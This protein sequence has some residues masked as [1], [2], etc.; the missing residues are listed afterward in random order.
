MQV[1]LAVVRLVLEIPVAVLT[2][3]LAARLLGVRRSWLATAS[4][5]TVAWILAN[6]LW[7]AVNHWE[8]KAAGVHLATI[9]LSLVFAMLAAVTFDFAARPGSLAREDR[10][11][12]IVFP[13]PVRELRRH[14]VP[15]I[16]YREIIR[17]A[18]R[19]GLVHGV[20][21]RRRR[22]SSSPP[23]DLNVAVRTTLEASGVVMTKLGQMAS[24]RDDLLPKALTVEL[25]RLQQHVEPVA[26]EEMQAE[27]EAELGRAVN[28]V[29]ADFSWE[30]I[31]SA[32]IAQ[33]YRA[34]LHGGD[35]VVVKVQRPGI[36]RVVE[37]DTA[38]LAH[39]AHTFERRTLE[40]RR[41]RASELAEEFAGG[42][43]E[44]LDFALEADNAVD[45]ATIDSRVR[46]PR[47][48]RELS[49]RRILV[50]EELNGITVADVGSR[51]IVDRA[52]LADQLVHAMFAQVMHGHFHAD[53]H[54][55]N[56]LLLDDGALGLIDFGSTGRLDPA[57]RSALMDIMF[58][59]MQRDG[60]GLR[61]AIEQV[62]DIDADVP[63][64]RLER[65]LE[66]FAAESNRGSTM[67]ARALTSL[68][69]L[70][71]TFDI[72]L[73]REF[74]MLFRALILLDGTAQTICPGYSLAE[75]MTRVLSN[76]SPVGL[77]QPVAREWLHDVSRLRRLPAQ[78]DRIATLAAHGNFQVRLALFSTDRDAQVVKSLVNR[79]VLA[80]V[81]AAV[82]L[83][84]TIMLLA[85][86]D[87]VGSSTAALTRVLGLV[88]LAAAAVLL[89]R[90]VA[91]IVREGYN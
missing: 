77:R 5:G 61:E 8:W 12:M 44:E 51:P 18:R 57:E 64:E 80:F 21:I 23:V 19:N 66:H 29:F 49:T 20:S 46:I 22:A 76:E 4:A 56:V 91:A 52:E 27:L 74:T 6:M 82:A 48:Y 85:S 75:G 9:A 86:K 33:T 60:A 38:A 65:A 90:V 36:E 25:A 37:H 15:Y 10:A 13:H 16:R 87:V 1:F 55:G 11:G 79:V 89:L 67:D 17:I 43:R 73:P 31:G 30:P 81:G 72:R 70:L 39:L 34:R 35:R 2:T 69:T 45:I 83:G 59:A 7:V 24:T 40:G 26:R 41:L 84:S 50:E 78:I 62:T 54:P 88:G 28:E 3:L 42:L 32:S 63:Q 58:A 53:P 68:V 47:V 14:L 71:D